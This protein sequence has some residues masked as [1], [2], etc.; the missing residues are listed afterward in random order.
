MKR[1]LGL[2]PEFR[3]PLEDVYDFLSV[4]DE[5]VLEVRVAREGAVHTWHLNADVVRREPVHT[6]QEGV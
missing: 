6:W 1:S 3:Q 4:L 2:Y 5:V